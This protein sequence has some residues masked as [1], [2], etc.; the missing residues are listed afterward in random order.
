M[1]YETIAGIAERYGAKILY[2]ERIAGYTS[3]NI[4]GICDVIVMPNSAECIADIVS[5]CKKNGTKLYIFGKCTNVLISDNGL[6][7]VVML[8]DG[9]YS[10]VR[11]VGNTLVCDAGA[12]VTKI[13]N[14]AKNEGLTGLEFAY[15]IPGSAGGALYMNAGAYG[16]EMKDVVSYCTYL[17]T[18]GSVKRMEKA[19]M[20]LSYR[21]SVFTG[22]D[23]IILSVCFELEE[24]DPE[25]IAADMNDIMNRRREK[26][27][28]EYPSAGSTFKRP[29]GYF[30][31][32]LIEDSGLRGLT[33]GGAQ[34]SEKHCGFVI[35]KGGATCED[36]LRLI[37][38]IKSKV[39]E[40][41]GVKL[42]CEVLVID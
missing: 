42:E 31:G 16:G 15:G 41:S 34:V 19:E 12:S 33:V 37:D 4:G 7:G 29:E 40:H 22:T 35:N 39:S 5:C 28:L 13:C 2:N 32:N 20:G 9:E 38:S 10:Q 14:T 8:I 25:K 23:R 11:R 17:D 27:P 30:A 6:R 21:R 18:D 36:V 26:Q 1:S 24:G 3:F